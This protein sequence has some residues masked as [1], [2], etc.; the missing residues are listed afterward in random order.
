MLKTTIFG[1]LLWRLGMAVGKVEKVI[2]NF[3]V[4]MRT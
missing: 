1:E 2:V 3:H 4:G